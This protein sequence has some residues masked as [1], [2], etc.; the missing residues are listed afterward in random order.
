MKS[1][2]RHD[3]KTNELERIASELGHTA[4]HYVH[5]NW[6][7]LA[8]AVVAIL[9]GAGGVVYWRSSSGSAGQ[10]G[11]RE[12]AS[13]SKAADYGNVADKY[14]GSVAAAWARLLE[15]EMEL[16]S[17][18]RS[19]F[20]DRSAGRSD[21]QKAQENFEKLIADKATPSDVIERALFGL[22]RAK[23]ALPPKDLSPSKINDGAIE[24]Y[25]RL[26]TDFPISVYKEYA[27]AR[28]AALKTGT[29]QDFY[30][31][32]EQQNPKPADREMP[33]DLIPP[34][35]DETKTATGTPIKTVPPPATTKA[36]GKG[37]AET[38][39]AAGSPAKPTAPAPASKKPAT[40]EGPAMPLPASP[41]K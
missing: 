4:E 19:S 31:W 2:H 5:D 34:S 7:L 23:E 37:A 33:K 6:M 38:K 40:E 36:P 18:I 25:Q 21:L 41:T 20:T 22:A 29:A 11:W 32:F 28:I 8:A 27:E 26:V 3:L 10:Q 15:G 17:G 30:A 1:E 13:A 12:F 14:S 39:P 24:T 9:I 35:P 16:N